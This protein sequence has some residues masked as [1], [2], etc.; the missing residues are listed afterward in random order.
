M[1]AHGTHRSRDGRVPL[2][3]LL[4]EAVAVLARAGIADPAVDAELLAGHVLHASRG[5]VQAQVVLNASLS[6]DQASAL[7]SV[8]DRRAGREPLQHITGRAP[9]RSLQLRV[10]PGVFVPRPETELLA[11]LAIDALRAAAE[12]EPIGVDLG[13]GSGAVALSMA[14][15]VPHARVVAVERS[16]EAYRW[17]RLNVEEAGAGN[18]EL[19]HGD[20]ADALGHLDGRVAVVA[21][22][23]PYVPDDAVPRDPEV[24][25]FDP[26]AALYGGPDGLDVVRVLSHRALRLA[27][28]GG[29][30]AIE[31]GE[32]QGEAVRG[33]LDA[34]GWRSAATHRDLTLRDRVTTASR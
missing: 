25:G 26:A 23:P 31:H 11:Q 10:G 24:R 33:I 32:L 21:S 30:L 13:A 20:L 15:E 14:L 1:D 7:R 4:A 5:G 3:E 19:V 17:A 27:R 22:N 18:V 2:R 29:M 9:F 8:V 12:P 34:D 28:P 16:P 6:E